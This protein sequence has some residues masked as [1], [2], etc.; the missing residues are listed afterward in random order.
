M[1]ASRPLDATAAAEDR[2]SVTRNVVPAPGMLSSRDAAAVRLDDRGHDRQAEARAAVVARARGVAAVEA[3]EDVCGLLGVEPG[4]GVG[5][6]E[7]GAAAASRRTR[8]VAA[9]S[10]GVCAR[11]F[12]SRLSTT[13]RR[14]SASPVTVTAA[15]ASSASGRAGSIAC[16]ASIASPAS[17]VR[18]SGRASS[19]R[20]WSSR[21]SSSRS[22]TSRPMRRVSRWMPVIERSR[23]AGRSR[24]PRSK[25]SAYA[26]TAAIG[27]RSSCEA[28]EMKRRRRASEAERSANASSICPSIA[29][30][31]PPSRPISVVPPSGSTRRERS[32][33]PMAAA[34]SS[35]RRSGR[36]LASDQPEA[37]QER[38]RD[39][40]A[41]RR[42]A[43]S[44]LSW[45]SVTSV[46]CSGTPRISVESANGTDRA[47]SRK[48]AALRRSP[49]PAAA[50][51]SPAGPKPLG[52]LGH[53]AVSPGRRNG[54]A[55]GCE[56]SPG[57]ISTY[58]PGVSTPNAA[59]PGSAEGGAAGP[60]GRGEADAAGIC[61]PAR[62]GRR[63]SCRP[64]RTTTSAARHRSRDRPRGG[65]PPRRRRARA[66]AGR[67]ATFP[68]PPLRCARRCGRRSPA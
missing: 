9:A 57:R 30:S 36:R 53:R 37:E 68:A 15:G 67:A 54:A 41:G 20:P 50:P 11:T 44:S 17:A 58:I 13:W 29:F 35:M 63:A 52:M 43:R 10:A 25:S 62:T 51:P 23:S 24:A 59:R 66:A 6:L 26:L 60:G 31:A 61:D 45:S 19:G 21:A 27:V 65:R 18:S 64:A 1:S 22:P 33:A 4:P 40:G 32:P 49:S 12:A 39:H 28:S 38:A 34:V 46:S 14:R 56:P 42:A 8:T 7:H 55:E 5:D 2:G 16:A 47:R 48:R 3:L